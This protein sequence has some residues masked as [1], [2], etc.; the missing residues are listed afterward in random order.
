MKASLVVSLFLSLALR[1]SA[2][3]VIMNSGERYI[4]E[5]TEDGDTIRLKNPTFPDG[6]VLKRAEVK[7]I[8]PKPEV[9]IEKLN[10]ETDVAQA[11]YEEGKKAADP[12]P[13]LKAAID[14]LFDPELEAQEAAEVYPAE[15]AKFAEVLTRMHDL[16]K[17]CRDAQAMAGPAVK[18]EEKGKPPVGPAPKPGEK[19]KPGDTPKPGDAPK[20][21]EPAKPPMKPAESGD[22][23]AVVD[24]IRNGAPGDLAGALAKVEVAKEERLATPLVERLRAEKDPQARAVLKEA[25]TKLPGTLAVRVIETAI[26]AKGVSDEFRRD[27]CDILVGK[28]DEKSVAIVADVAF[29]SEMRETRDYAR[30]LLSAWGNATLKPASRYVHCADA[31]TRVTAVE[32]VAGI[33]TPEAYAVLA[34]C[35]IIGTSDELMAQSSIDVPIRDLAIE[36]LVSG[37]DKA[38]PALVNALSSGS[39]RKWAR[40]ALQ[41]ISGQN[42]QETD[43]ANW[44]AWWRKRKAEIG[45]K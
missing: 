16:R 44:S 35:L 11:K 21:V 28:K 17:M 32:F 7:A 24:I 27:C 37:G 2:D 6:L 13:F 22:V 39:L 18:P 29:A 43:V 41:K 25:M 31:K 36:K 34:Q 10:K 45:G 8:Y 42:Y 40:F 33:D 15:K 19:P 12:N 30:G 20:T 5:V 38:C 3:A 4:G 9:M 14:A 23:A 1:A 26:K